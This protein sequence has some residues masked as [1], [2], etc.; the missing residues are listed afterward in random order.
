MSRADT[1]L[2]PLHLSAMKNDVKG[3]KLLIDHGAKVEATDR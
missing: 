3:C 2:T 1:G